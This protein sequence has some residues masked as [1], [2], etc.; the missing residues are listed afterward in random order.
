MRPDDGMSSSY[1]ADRL[2][3]MARMALE[4]GDTSQA[5]TDAAAIPG[6]SPG[7][8][9]EPSIA[10]RLV[11]EAV[12]VAA[13]RSDLGEE[14]RRTLA[15]QHAKVAVGLLQQAIDRNYPYVP[16]L[17][18]DPAFDSLRSYPEF[19]ALKEPP[20]DPRDLSPQRFVF[21]Y[22][23]DDPG[24]RSWQREG[25]RWVEIQPSGNRNEY[26]IVGRIRLRGVSGTE[27]VHTIE[28][29]F[30]LFI[31][32]KDSTPEPKLSMRREPGSWSNLGDIRGV[33]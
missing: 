32:D 23:H 9:E 30:Y 24:P 5:V 22:A 4:A 2:Q 15:A 21:D 6:N 10:A 33:K 11:A 17:A 19:L 7:R 28:K 1:I 18:T 13:T 12:A 16:E 14:E 29:G 3:G 20:P 31:P 26:Q 8:W 27:V 25:D